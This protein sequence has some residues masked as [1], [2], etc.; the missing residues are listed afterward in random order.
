MS[1]L[2][3]Y[4]LFDSMYNEPHLELYNLSLLNLLYECEA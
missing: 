2:K 3:K 1:A 4:K